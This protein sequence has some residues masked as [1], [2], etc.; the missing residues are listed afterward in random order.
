LPEFE[1]YGRLGRDALWFGGWT[2][3]CNFMVTFEENHKSKA[4][5]GHRVIFP[6][7]AV[8]FCVMSS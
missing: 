5:F 1:G 8:I 6:F 7:A 4:L 3:H 2:P